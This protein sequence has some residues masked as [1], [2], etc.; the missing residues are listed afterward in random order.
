VNIENFKE[1]AVVTGVSDDISE[2][3][4][5]VDSLVQTDTYYIPGMI[6]VNNRD[7]RTV[8]KCLTVGSDRVLTLSRAFPSTS[9]QTGDNVEVFAGD[10]LTMEVCTVVFGAATNSGEA[11]GGWKWTPNKDYQRVGIR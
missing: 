1:T 7:M 6:R 4:I 3:T 2:P 11:W 10:D 9:V 8:I 5:T